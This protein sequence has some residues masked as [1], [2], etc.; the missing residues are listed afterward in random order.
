MNTRIIVRSGY[1]QLCEMAYA[2]QL[3]DA[4]IEPATSCMLSMR[5]TNWAKPP[6][7]I[8][9]RM[10]QPG[11]EPGAQ[12]WQ[13]WILPLNHW[14]FNLN[15]L[16]WRSGK[17][18]N[19]YILRNFY[20][21]LQLTLLTWLHLSHLRVRLYHSDPGYVKHWLSG[22]S[23]LLLHMVNSKNNMASHPWKYIFPFNYWVSLLWWSHYFTI[24][25]QTYDRKLCYI[26]EFLH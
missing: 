25:V 9:S 14:H 15:F 22:A 24:K 4:G 10:R 18:F 3:E 20:T 7:Y 11:I 13:R 6:N 19:A 1:I 8:L 26:G 16:S 5:S 2:K 23:I 21:F 17:K 12:R